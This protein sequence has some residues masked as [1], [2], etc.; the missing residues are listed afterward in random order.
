LSSSQLASDTLRGLAGALSGRYSI[1]LPGG[2]HLH[3][4]R[5][6][7]GVAAAAMVIDGDL[8]LYWDTDQPQAG[9]HALELVREHAPEL[10]GYLDSIGDLLDPPTGEYPLLVPD[11]PLAEVG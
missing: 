11:A 6:P 1:D 10:L 2:I 5:L 7:W 3:T 4:R 9:R 8:Y